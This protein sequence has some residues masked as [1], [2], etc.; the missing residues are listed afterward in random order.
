MEKI[1]ADHISAREFTSKNI[2]NF[3]NLIR[4]QKTQFKM[5]KI[6]LNR[7]FTRGDTQ[8]TNKCMNRYSGNE[9]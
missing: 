9:N 1:F 7:Y 5:G 6:Y 8:T 2:K 3:Y 4:R